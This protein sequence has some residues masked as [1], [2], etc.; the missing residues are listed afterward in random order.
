MT[1]SK[2]QTNIWVVTEW[3]ANTAKIKHKIRP[4]DTVI[5]NGDDEE[6]LRQMAGI[7]CH[8]V[9]F[10]YHLK[11]TITISGREE[12]VTTGRVTYVFALQRPMLNCRKSVLEPC[13]FRWSVPA[14]V[15]TQSVMAAA[16]FFLVADVAFFP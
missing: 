13:E 10:G 14:E 1:V 6:L 15:T 5:L 11:S 12:D 4:E 8:T 7:V 2:N 16:A 3:D 9:T